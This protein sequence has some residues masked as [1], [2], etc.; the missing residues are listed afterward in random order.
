MGVIGGGFGGRWLVGSLS[1]RIKCSVRFE[2]GLIV[3]E[4][5]AEAVADGGDLVDSASGSVGPMAGSGTPVRAGCVRVAGEEVDMKVGY[6]IA[7]H[8]AV[9]VLCTFAVFERSAETV[10]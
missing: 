4:C 8:E 2:F 1:T 3:G 6:F 7:E 10:D 5:S 9:D